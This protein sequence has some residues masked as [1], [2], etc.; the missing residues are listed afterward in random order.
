[1]SIRARSKSE[2]RLRQRH[3][4]TVRVG[5]SSVVTRGLTSVFLPGSAVM[6]ERVAE[7][8]NE[9]RRQHPDTGIDHR[10][11][12]EGVVIGR[13]RTSETRLPYSLEARSFS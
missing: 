9:A 12:S 13:R 7:E 1:M 11:R 5:T 10:V 2:T 6:A 4:G 8:L 3:D